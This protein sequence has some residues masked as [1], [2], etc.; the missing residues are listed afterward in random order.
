MLNINKCTKTKPKP[1]PTLIF[2]NCSYVSAY[3]CAQLSYTAQHRTVLII[4]LLS[5]RQREDKAVTKTSSHRRRRYDETVT[6]LGVRN[7]WIK[8]A[9]VWTVWTVKQKLDGRQQSP[10]QFTL[11]TRRRS[12]FCRVGG[13]NWALYAII[14]KNVTVENGLSGRQWL[15]LTTKTAKI[16]KLIL[17]SSTSQMHIVNVLTSNN[18]FVIFAVL[19]VTC[20]HC[21]LYKPFATVKLF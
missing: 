5:F 7:V 3:H 2:K 20:S 14:V 11:T 6:F 1:K 4:F 16:K 19:T 10:S 9:T 8:S 21:R 18:T 12:T 15:H 13:A 17:L